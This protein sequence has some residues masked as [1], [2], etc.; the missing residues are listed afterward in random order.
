MFVPLYDYNAWANHRVWDC[1]QQL[2][3]EQF[4]RDIDYSIGSIHNQVAHTTRESIRA[5]WDETEQMIRAYVAQLTP[6]ELARTVRPPFWDA[7]QPAIKV[8]EALFQV[9]NHSTDHRAQTLAALHRVGG[10][11]TPQDLLFY[12]FDQAGVLWANE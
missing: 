1:V 12:T 4:D 3:R 6:E 5:K 8:F 7:G 11:T 2:S 10:P 9:A